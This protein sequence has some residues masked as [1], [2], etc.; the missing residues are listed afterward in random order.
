MVIELDCLYLLDFVHFCKRRRI[1]FTIKEWRKDWG[2]MYAMVQ[3]NSRGDAEQ[4]AQRLRG[5]KES[6]I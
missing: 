1:L 2:A 6:E 5:I 4:W 3:M